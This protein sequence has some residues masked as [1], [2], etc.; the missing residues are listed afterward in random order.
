MFTAAIFDMDGLLLDSERPVRDAWFT[1][2]RRHGAVMTE[3]IYLECI[4]RNAV[5][6]DAV[7]GPVFEGVMPYAEACGEVERILEATWSETGYA[8]KPGVL[9]LLQWLREADIPCAVASSTHKEEVIHR[10]QKAGLLEFF[11]SVSGGDEVSRGKPN[12]DLFLLASDR[13]RT[14][15]QHC[16]VFEDS[17]FGAMAGL[18]AGMSVVLVPDLKIAS[19]EVQRQ[20]LTVLDSLEGTLSLRAEWF[21]LAQRKSGTVD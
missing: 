7:L 17:E 1:L 5:D 10:L 19:A 11:D 9:D 2:A 16:V 4:G 14:S 21:A 3:A 15:P 12:P 20:C 18:S 13:I 6:T 8:P